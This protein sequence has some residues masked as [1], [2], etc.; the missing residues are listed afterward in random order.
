MCYHNRAL[1]MHCADS[2]HWNHRTLQCDLRE[3]AHCKVRSEHTGFP[4]CPPNA[5][6]LYAHP[7][8]CDLFLYCN[9][10][11]MQVQ[12]CPF[13]QHWDIE[14][15]RCEMRTLARCGV[16]WRPS[17]GATHEPDDADADAETVDANQMNSYD[18]DNNIF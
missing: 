7:L 13:Y 11:D 1:R 9:H 4:E 17:V 18:Y 12:Q 16:G 2:L 8:R 5:V 14:L 10:G 15:E 3:R 6:G